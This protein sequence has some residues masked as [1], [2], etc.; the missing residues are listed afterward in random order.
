MAT[1]FERL[2]RNRPAEAVIEQPSQEP[3][4]KTL[5]LAP[6]LGPTNHH[7]ARYS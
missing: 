2:S 6:N 5:D 7:R 4:P 1:L 3:S